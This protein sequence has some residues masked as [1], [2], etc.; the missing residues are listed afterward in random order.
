[1]KDRDYNLGEYYKDSYLECYE[2]GLEDM[3][4]DQSEFL[5]NAVKSCFTEQTVYSNIFDDKVIVDLFKKNGR[6]NRLSLDTSK[7]KCTHKEC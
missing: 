1:M 6:W 4:K 7:R 3:D 2:N 5:V